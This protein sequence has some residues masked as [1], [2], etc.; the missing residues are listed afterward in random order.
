LADY[1]SSLFLSL[2]RSCQCQTPSPQNQSSS[3]PRPFSQPMSISLSENPVPSSLA[4]SF[5][6]ASS[7]ILLPPLF[8]YQY[9]SEMG[10]LFF[11]CKNARKKE[12]QGN[13]SISWRKSLLIVRQ[14]TAGVMPQVAESL[15]CLLFF[16]EKSGTFASEKNRFL[17]CEEKNRRQICVAIVL[18]RRLF[19][20]TTPLSTACCDQRPRSA[21]RPSNRPESV[22]ERYVRQ[23]K[24]ASVSQPVCVCCPSDWGEKGTNGSQTQVI[25]VGQPV[26]VLILD[27]HVAELDL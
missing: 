25:D 10:H 16:M 7:A 15:A 17:G 11:F 21:S 6:L 24:I 5:S 9:R 22:C 18:L 4:K 8:I 20:F 26:V 19:G 3:Q 14:S 2:R 23:K 1:P 12:T 13:R 27:E